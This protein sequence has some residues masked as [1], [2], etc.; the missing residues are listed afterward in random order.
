MK[1]F[2][3]ISFIKEFFNSNY[4]GDDAF[5][6]NNLLISKDILI[7]NVH[8]I[9]NDNFFEIGAKSLISNLSDIVAM[10]GKPE[11]FFMGLGIP[12]RV[13]FDNLEEFFKGMKYIADNYNVILGGGDISKSLNDFFISITVTGFPF[14]KPIKRDNAKESDSIFIIGEVGDSEIGLRLIKNEF[15]CNNKEY[16]IKKHYIKDLYLEV[17]KELVEKG[18]INS[19]IDIS[20][21]FIQD[22]GHILNL[23]N[24]S[25][26]IYVKNFPVS[27]EYKKLKK[28]LKDD[29]YIIPLISGEEYSLIFTSD[30]KYDK[31]ILK[32]SSTF[33]VR[34]TKVG[35]VVEKKK[36]L[37]LFKD[38]KIKL[39]KKGY[40]HCLGEG[41]NEY[42]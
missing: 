33:G 26:E 41:K 39:N 32:T 22:L 6:N 21:G 28:F 1:E 7:E 20:D 42:C 40:I 25:A 17:V 31:E 35:E 2:E 24:K 8:F 23:S 18:I 34:I 11:F 12:D 5:Y 15:F 13:K 9:L 10:G 4:I 30:K 37:I 14:K 29:Y 38:Y 36:H 19:M 3:L 27:D 16:F